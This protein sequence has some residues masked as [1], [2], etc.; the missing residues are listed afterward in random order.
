MGGIKH[1]GV[2][3]QN[4]AH[5]RTPG[6]VPKPFGVVTRAK[7]RGGVGSATPRAG[8]K[9]SRR[10]FESANDPAL[11]MGEG[12]LQLRDL[13]WLRGQGKGQH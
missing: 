9:L 4:L 5:L 1:H 12:A 2:A 8:C 10:F 11:E 13:D 3:S 6:G 7:H